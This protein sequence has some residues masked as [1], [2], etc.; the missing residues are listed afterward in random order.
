MITQT[1]IDLCIKWKKDSYQERWDLCPIIHDAFV[2]GG[3]P[4]VATFH[5]NLVNK[6]DNINN[7]CC[8]RSCSGVGDLCLAVRRVLDMKEDLLEGEE[9]LAKRQL[10]HLSHELKYRWQHEEIITNSSNGNRSKA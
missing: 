2:D 1:M 10:I 7:I 9:N 5:F 4:S 3:Y 8:R 6:K